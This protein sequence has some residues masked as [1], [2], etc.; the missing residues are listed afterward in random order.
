M[1]YIHTHSHKEQQNSVYR[2]MG[3]AGDHYVKQKT[4][5]VAHYFSHM[6]N[7]D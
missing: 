1:W 7:L 3:E 4:K 2:K 5:H 6:Q